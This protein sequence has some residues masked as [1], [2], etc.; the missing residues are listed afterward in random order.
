MRSICAAAFLEMQKRNQCYVSSFSIEI[1]K[2]PRTRRSTLDAGCARSRMTSGA[3]AGRRRWH[4]DQC[5][6]LG[7][8]YLPSLPIVIYY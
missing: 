6:A 8:L 4:I 1:E 5:P 3:P 2:S 7:D